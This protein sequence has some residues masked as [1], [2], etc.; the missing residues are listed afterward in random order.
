MSRVAGE[1]MPDVRRAG[2]ASVFVGRRHVPDRARARAVLE[3]TVAGWSEHPWPAGVLSFSCYLSTE[4]DTVLTYAQCSDAYA[5]GAF[6]DA[7]D[8]PAGRRAADDGVRTW[9]RAGAVEYRLRASVVPEG[10]SGAPACMVIATFDVD[11]AGRQDA[12]IGSL[13]DALRAHPA[14]R[15]P[16]M[17]SANFHASV[18]A[19][20]VL[21]YAEWTSDEAHLAF[22][23]STAR[24][25]TM[26]ASGGIPGVRP[27][28][29]Q[30]YHL[31]RG[32]T[33]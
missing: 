20:R 24:D 11:D 5:R 7:P 14:G 33:R 13:V 6:P 16:G 25:A 30:R 4:E 22:L 12:V 10:A 28:G 29:F 23:D 27:I 26:R 18:D 17:L 2:V 9:P 32:M 31:H 3:R 21:N 8:G 1:G 15:P 19:T